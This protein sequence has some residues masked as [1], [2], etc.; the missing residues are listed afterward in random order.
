MASRE[1]WAPVEGFEGYYEVS[2][3]GNVKSVARSIKGISRWGTPLVRVTKERL[4]R[5]GDGHGYKRVVLC[6]DS[7][8]KGFPVHVLVAKAFIP[9]PENKPQ[10]N[11]KNGIRD[12]NR[13]ENLEWVTQSENQLHSFRVLG[14]K[15][16]GLGTKM[17]PELRAKLEPH[18]IKARHRGVRAV[19]CVETGVTYYSIAEASR[20]TNIK[21]PHISRCLAGGRK[22]CGGY[23][24][25]YVNG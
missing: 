25:R 8:K 4:L 17:S 13:V 14:R 2:N 21:K 9:N 15:P 12:D 10:V 19:T 20:C 3:K 7:Y 22:S 1:V 6:K 16:T 18:W 5:F 11:H 23:T 24:W